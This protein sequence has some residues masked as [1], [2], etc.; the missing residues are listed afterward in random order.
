MAR[1]SLLRKAAGLAREIIPPLLCAFRYLNLAKD[2]K[3]A[4]LPAMQQLR[5]SNL[6]SYLYLLKISTDGFFATDF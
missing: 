1:V 3:I 2:Q 4:V 6:R 5:T